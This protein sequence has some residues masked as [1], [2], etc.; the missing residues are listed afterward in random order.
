MSDDTTHPHLAYRYEVA[1]F[2]P[3]RRCA[4]LVP[5]YDYAAPDW[6]ATAWNSSTTSKY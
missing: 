4:T 1:V 2:R 3:R 6:S 5:C